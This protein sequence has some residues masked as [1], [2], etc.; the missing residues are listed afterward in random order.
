[1]PMMNLAKAIA[2]YLPKPS[3]SSG[4]I[5]IGNLLGSG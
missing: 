3:S 1:M 5:D 4:G 2:E